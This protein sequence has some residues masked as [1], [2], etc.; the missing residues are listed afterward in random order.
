MSLTKFS[1]AGCVKCGA[2]QSDVHLRYHESTSSD[3][4][5]PDC[6]D[7]VIRAVGPVDVTD[8]DLYDLV[9]EVSHMSHQCSVCRYTWITDTKDNLEEDSDE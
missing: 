5:S 7:A 1:K 8:A 2:P 4:C 3:W 9:I 6:E